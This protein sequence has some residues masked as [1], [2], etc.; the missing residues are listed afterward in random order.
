MIETQVYD[1]IE[2]NMANEKKKKLQFKLCNGWS[3]KIILKMF[4]FDQRHGGVCV[5]CTN[6]DA[7]YFHCDDI[8][9]ISHIGNGADF[10]R[11]V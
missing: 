3:K 11:T 10:E 7:V 1:E 5:A 2:R 8:K 4:L 9:M 6:W